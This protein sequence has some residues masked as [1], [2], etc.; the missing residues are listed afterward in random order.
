MRAGRPQ[1]AGNQ[2]MRRYYVTGMSVIYYVPLSI[3]L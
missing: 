3:D 1:A 2:G